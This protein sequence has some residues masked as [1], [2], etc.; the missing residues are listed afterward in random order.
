M[1]ECKG[2]ADDQLQFLVVPGFADIAID[3]TVVDGLDGGIDVG[4]AGEQN[5]DGY[6]GIGCWFAPIAIRSQA[7]SV[8]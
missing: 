3:L 6:V 2:L 5:P 7:S 8:G 1:L 4:V